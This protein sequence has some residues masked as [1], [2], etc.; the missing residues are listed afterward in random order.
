MLEFCWGL[1]DDTRNHSLTNSDELNG[2]Y[3]LL[4]K[5]PHFLI[6]LWK[7]YFQHQHLISANT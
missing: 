4:L 5:N 2:D 6:S 7:Q 3:E 1:Y